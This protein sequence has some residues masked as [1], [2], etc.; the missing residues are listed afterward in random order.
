ML[1]HNPT[2]PERDQILF[3]VLSLLGEL[4]FGLEP[5]KVTDDVAAQLVQLLESRRLITPDLA[6]IDHRNGP[7]VEALLLHAME[8]ALPPVPS[9]ATNSG[10]EE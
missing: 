8:I 1:R 3:S 6:S 10:L 2:R 9:P 4:K 5:A 7:I